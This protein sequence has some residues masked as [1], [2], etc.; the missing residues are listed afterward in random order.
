MDPH[1][2]GEADEIDNSFGDCR[3]SGGPSRYLENLQ[4]AESWRRPL[5]Q[6]I[7]SQRTTRTI[8]DTADWV[9]SRGPG[10]PDVVRKALP[11]AVTVTSSE[12]AVQDDRVPETSDSKERISVSYGRKNIVIGAIEVTP[13]ATFA[14][15]R[16]LVRPLLRRYLLG[17]VDEGEGGREGGYH[18]AAKL[19][20]IG[21]LLDGFT[22]RDSL[23]AL[24][25]TE[26]EP[27]SAIECHMTRSPVPCVR[28]CDREWKWT[29]GR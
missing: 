27:V 23:G 12:T 6:E 3:D 28:S 13:L 21:R 5:V 15:V 22:M 18:S 29:H 4:I 25:P 10:H 1:A 17:G 9:D 11:G 26:D 24:V 16:V 19:A 7:E 20:G 8:L 14:D 2:D